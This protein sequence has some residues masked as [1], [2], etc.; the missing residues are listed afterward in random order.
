MK[1]G[2]GTR[3]LPARTHR[4]RL[5]PDGP[6]ARVS[7]FVVEP[8]P[9]RILMQTYPGDIDPGQV[10]RWLKAECEVAPSTF[11]ISARRRQEAR[12]IPVRAETHLGDTER[13]DL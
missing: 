9:F 8:R 6:L 4:R 10:A 1:R 11:K 5:R 3:R 7:R 2:G 12:E 13:E